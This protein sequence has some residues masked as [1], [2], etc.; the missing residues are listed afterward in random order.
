[1]NLQFGWGRNGSQL[2]WRPFQVGFQLSSIG[3]AWGIGP[4]PDR[5]IMD[6]ALVFRLEE[7]R[8]RHILP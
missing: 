2:V 7:E 1:M 4:I 6:F 8:Q 5:G 3:I